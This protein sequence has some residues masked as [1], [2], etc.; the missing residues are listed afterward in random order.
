MKT[1]E[2]IDVVIEKYWKGETSLEEEKLLKKHF[3]NQSDQESPEQALSSYFSEEGS[4]TYTKVIEMPKSARRSYS[5]IISIAAT[6]LILIGA[7]WT[8]NNGNQAY[9][10]EIV[11]DDPQ[12]ALEITREAFALLNGKVGQGEEAIMDHIE[13]L[14]K[15]LIFKNL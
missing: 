13:H 4:K 5:I 11:I 2:N 10:N 9:S 1:I 15:T 7:L 3:S 8:F 12:V 14:D 6:L